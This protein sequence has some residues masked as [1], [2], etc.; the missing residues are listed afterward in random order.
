M[1]H[2]FKNALLFVGTSALLFAGCGDDDPKT[3]PDATTAD[4]STTDANVEIDAGPDTTFSGTLSLAEVSIT[5]PVA[6]SLGGIGGATVNVS[7]VSP[8]DVTVAPQPGYTNNIGGCRIF[9]YDVAAGQAAPAGSDGG[10][11]T[12]TGTNSGEFACNYNGALDTYLCASTATEASGAIVVAGTT[13]T[14]GPSPGTVVITLGGVDFGAFDPTGGSIILSDFVDP[15]ANGRFSVLGRIPK[16]SN[17]VLIANPA[18]MAPSALAQDST[19]STL[20]GTGPQPGGFDFLDDGTAQN[21]FTKAAATDAPEVNTMLQANGQGFALDA[22]SSSMPHAIPT[23]GTAVTFSCDSD[24]DPANAND[25]CGV[26]TGN[27]LKGMLIFGETT[28]G[29]LNPLDPFGMPAPVSKYA[30]YQCSAI[31]MK[32]FALDTGAMALILGTEPTRIQTTIVYS[33]AAIAGPNNLV[34]SHGVVG[35][36]DVPQTMNK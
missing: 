9:V 5:G 27:P 30:T 12:I 10:T 19:Y 35:F 22:A 6:A 18:L 11:V 17:A 7:F 14:L 26:D 13:A 25:T 8:S 31:G 20:V 4:A 36:T 34:V 23:D 1:L 28:D 3:T 24:D 16:T 15:A 32:K 29:A 2:N 33:S 21:V